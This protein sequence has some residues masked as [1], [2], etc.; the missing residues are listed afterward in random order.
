M[1]KVQDAQLTSY[2]L[3]SQLPLSEV[4]LMRQIKS[5]IGKKKKKKQQYLLRTSERPVNELL[6]L[7][8]I[9]I[10]IEM[11]HHCHQAVFI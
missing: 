7:C 2:L 6:L 9:I 5:V 4:E 10:V 11:S 1:G 8:H 3:P